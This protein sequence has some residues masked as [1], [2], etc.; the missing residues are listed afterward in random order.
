MLIIIYTEC[1]KIFVQSVLY[2]VFIKY[3]VFFKYSGFWP[4]SVFPRCQC[5][6]THQAGRKPALQQNLQKTQYLMNTLYNMYLTMGNIFIES[7][8]V[9]F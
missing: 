4:F 9:N 3:C 1:Y 7:A 8:T 5:V 2:R 6:C